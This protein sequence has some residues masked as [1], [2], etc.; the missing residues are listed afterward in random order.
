MHVLIGKTLN[1]ANN[2]R[3]SWEQQTEA[4]HQRQD[5]SAFR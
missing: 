4:K 5:F 3:P 2:Q 1:V